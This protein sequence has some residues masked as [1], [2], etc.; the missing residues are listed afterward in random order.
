MS[1]L[2]NVIADCFWIGLAVGVLTLPP[3]V[4]AAEGEEHHLPHNHLALIIGTAMERHDGHAENGNILGIE[5]ERWYSE[6]WGIGGVF[7]QEAFGDRTDRHA[8]LA[9][10]ISYHVNKHWRLFLAPGLEFHERGDPEKPL[11]RLG[12]GYEFNL[13]GHF[14]FAPEFQIDF[15]AGGAKVYVFSLTLGYGF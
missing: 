4:F 11:L 3:S 6:K 9:V 8:I 15:V 1:K 13:S 2:T 5:Y 10:P 14:T 7:E 12:T